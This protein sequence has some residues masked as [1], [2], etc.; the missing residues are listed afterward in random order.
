M[1]RKYVRDS[2]GQFAT[3]GGKA[4]G[5]AAKAGAGKGSK[6]G[7]AAK[8]GAGPK[9]ASAAAPKSLGERIGLALSN[10]KKRELRTLER[11]RRAEQDRAFNDP[12]N[13]GPNSG[14][15]YDL[16]AKAIDRKYDKQRA[17]IKAKYK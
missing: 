14:N 13:S 6:A 11:Q 8:A 17:A 3:T 4:A 10:P 5:S 15:R 2:Q 16:K 12:K 7:A 9:A 1:T